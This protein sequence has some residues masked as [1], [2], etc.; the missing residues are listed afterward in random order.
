MKHKL[1]LPVILLIVLSMS[2]TASASGYIALG[3]SYR[4]FSLDPLWTAPNWQENLKGSLF[5]S[6]GTIPGVRINLASYIGYG[7]LEAPPAEVDPMPSPIVSIT[8]R[9]G[10][11]YD[12]LKY[13]KDGTYFGFGPTAGMSF[14]NVSFGATAGKVD[15]NIGAQAF[16]SLLSGKVEMEG[17]VSYTFRDAFVNGGFMLRYNPV[18]P[19]ILFAGLDYLRRDGLVSLGA[20]FKF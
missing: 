3:A 12:L 7:G 18:G 5:L 17:N 15:F 2:L 10:I 1:L 13:A 16:L 19:L 11:D 20:G 6:L 14:S 8:A 4:S 9:A